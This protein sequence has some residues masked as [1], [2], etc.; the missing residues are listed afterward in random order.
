MA[1]QSD[2]YIVPDVLE[3]GLT[4]VFCGRAPSPESAR[5]RAYYAHFSNKFWEIL[6]ESGLTERQ[7][8]PE[9]YAQLPS[10]GIGLT[11]IN[12]TEF[13]SDHEL[14]GSG[15]NPRALFDKIEQFQPKI[16]AFNGKNNFRMFV[17]EAYGISK[18]T[19]VD[20]GLQGELTIKSTEIWV[21]PNTSA[22]A[23]GYWD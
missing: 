4:T 16:L 13:G 14:T 9:E 22:R 6:T 3:S 1:T 21:L 17:N 2:S 5:R 11:D 10:Y 20:Y 18:S 7:L 19:P 8:D 12:K 23:R 15:D